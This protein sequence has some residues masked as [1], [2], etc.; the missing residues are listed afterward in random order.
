MDTIVPQCNGE[1]W[2][3][4]LTSGKIGDG[5]VTVMDATVCVKS[6]SIL[7]PIRENADVTF[8][9]LDESI[10][11]LFDSLL[12]ECEISELS[13]ESLSPDKN[14]KRAAS[15][16][17]S[18]SSSGTVINELKDLIRQCE[19]SSDDECEVLY[20]GYQAYEGNLFVRP[21]TYLVK[22]AKSPVSFLSVHDGQESRATFLVKE[23]PE[24]TAKT[25]EDTMKTPEDI[26]VPACP[27]VASPTGDS[28]K[29]ATT[30][31]TKKKRRLR[32]RIGNFLRK[33]FCFGCIP[34]AHVVPS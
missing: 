32:T 18:V 15:G 1:E 30:T 2:E 6:Y 13:F 17:L 23:A 28:T 31:P 8:E 33:V 25:P 21:R 27:D 26:E 7:P 5:A 9:H 19:E 16:D 24:Y 11:A 3:G 10:D 4:L 14:I 34:S 12:L 22:P 20:S 29:D